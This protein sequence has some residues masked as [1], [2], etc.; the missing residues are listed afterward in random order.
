MKAPS[1]TCSLTEIPAWD[2]TSQPHLLPAEDSPHHTELS[3]TAFTHLSCQEIS[4]PQ[5]LQR[6]QPESTSLG[7]R[8]A[9]MIFFDAIQH[10]QLDSLFIARSSV[11]KDDLCSCY[12]QSTRYITNPR[13][14]GSVT[15]PHGQ[16]GLLRDAS[17][18]N[19]WDLS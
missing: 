18:Q 6:K 5:H 7:I 8:A 16:A 11:W 4:Q 9:P 3:C 2:G 12:H 13:C 10:K 14:A 15:S 19:I 1:L 17:R